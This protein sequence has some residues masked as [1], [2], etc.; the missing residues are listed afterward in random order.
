MAKL[1]NLARMTTATT[2]TGTITLGAA[3]SGYLT[4]ALAGVSD[5]DLVAYGISDG[6]NSEVGTGVYTNTF[7]DTN[8]LMADISSGI[9]TS[10]AYRY[11]RI[12]V[13]KQT[14]EN[15]YPVELIF[16]DAP[17][18]TNNMTLVTTS[19]TSDATV[20]NGRVLIEFDNTA[21]PTLN[22]D[23][24][25]EV[26]CDGS[27]WT[28][29]TL[30]AVTS[31]SQGTRKVVETVDQACTSGTSFAARIKTL[32]NKSVPIYGVSLTVH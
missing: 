10:T 6:S 8:G 28:A 25:V 2:S 30:S 4:F 15:I 9:T 20:S 29:A 18:S 11:H 17:A 13:T 26:Q 31:N 23:L 32:N 14:G 12:L 21:T 3:V 7:T 22:T 27:T 5:G 24:T 16:Y 19:Q 1:F